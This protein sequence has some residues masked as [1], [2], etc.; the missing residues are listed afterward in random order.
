MFT[1]KTRHLMAIMLAA[2]VV[3]PF[4]AA[5]QFSV[6]AKLGISQNQ[7][8]QPGT[9][10]GFSG[11][12]Y[13][14]YK[15]L[16]F[17]N[18]KFEPQYSQQGGSRQSYYIDYSALQGNVRYV[19]FINPSAIMQN[20]ELPILAEVTLPEFKDE[21]IIPK[22]ILGGSYS[23]MMKA[24]ER[25]TMRYFFND[26]TPAVDVGYQNQ[27]VTDNYAR[28]QFSAI[29]GLGILFKTEKRDF[30]FDVRYRQGFT[31][32]NLI[33]YP[34]AI[35]NNSTPSSFPGLPAPNGI[36]GNLYSSSLSINFSM[37]ILNF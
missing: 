32:L 23:L 31:Q 2:M 29:V 28:N 18:V 12:A 22:L 25:S 26:G 34:D 33:K 14:S 27:N 20:L 6:G 24:T 7:F 30:Q 16:P 19:G 9:V 8:S 4:G 21:K 36:G 3:L 17:L 1:K 15:V 5:A 35:S 13:V 10:V 37:T 11:G